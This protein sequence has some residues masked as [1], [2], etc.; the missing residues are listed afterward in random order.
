MSFKKRIASYAA[1]ASLV[2]GLIL[3]GAPAARAETGPPEPYDPSEDGIGV[4]IL[5]LIAVA[6]IATLAIWQGINDAKK[7]KQAEMEK[8]EESEEMEEYEEY[9]EFEPEESD[10]GEGETRTADEA[11]DAAEVAKVETLKAE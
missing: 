8:E 4:P 2:A 5:G 10:E 11:E 9:F 6:G 3:A 7:K 1:A